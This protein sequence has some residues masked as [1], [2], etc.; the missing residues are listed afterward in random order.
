MF[1]THKYVFIAA[2]LETNIPDRISFISK[3]NSQVTALRLCRRKPSI[4]SGANS[5]DPDQTPHHVA[6]G[7]GLQ[8]FATCN[9]I[10]HQKMN[11][12]DKNRP[13]T[14]KMTNG[15]VQHIT[16]E[17]STSIQWVKR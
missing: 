7:Q 12:S 16:V 11:K 14:S 2:L 1:L 13:D 9:R 10:F 8:C 17:E 15:L 5:A 3:M 6:S 4:E